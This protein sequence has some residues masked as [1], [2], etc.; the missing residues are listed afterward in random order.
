MAALLDDAPGIH[1]Q[2]SVGVDDSRQ[3]MGDGER[4]VVLGHLR[5]GL[6]NRLLGMA[7][8]G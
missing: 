8:Q 3:P 1:D 2:N 7:V 4:G 6:L 5:Q